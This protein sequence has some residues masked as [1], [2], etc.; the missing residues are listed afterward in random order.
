MRINLLQRRARRQIHQRERNDSRR[1]YCGRPRKNNGGSKC[2]KKLA[3]RS[4]ASKKQQ[5]KKTNYSGRKYQ[6]QDKYS[7][8]QRRTDSGA[9][10]PP[11]SRGKPDDERKNRRRNA[12]RERN[13][14]GRPIHRGRIVLGLIL[15]SLL[16]QSALRRHVKESGNH[17]SGISRGPR[18]RTKTRRRTWHQE[19]FSPPSK[20]PQDRRSV[21]AN[22]PGR[23][24]RSAPSR[25]LAHRFGRQVPRRRC[26][27]PPKVSPPR[28]PS[29]IRFFSLRTP[30]NQ[31][32]RAFAVGTFPPGR[33]PA[34][35]APQF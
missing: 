30:A 26:P 11:R 7:I 15:S 2:Q 34:R 17:A 9:S 3:E 16:F 20:L 13:P 19:D 4:V 24:Q 25:I 32:F 21:R 27:F 1:D 33:E 5:E 29:P 28:T 18:Y 35:R 22:P 8:N 6:R 12:G 10:L 31:G 14:Q 23:R